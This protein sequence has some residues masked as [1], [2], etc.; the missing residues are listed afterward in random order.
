MAR[1]SNDK[2]ESE[3]GL[4]MSG[5]YN[6]GDHIFFR[7]KLTLASECLNRE[8]EVFLKKFEDLI[9]GVFCRIL[10]SQL[11]FKQD[12]YQEKYIPIRKEMDK[13][14][15]YI[16]LEPVFNAWYDSEENT[17]NFPLYLLNVFK[18]LYDFQDLEKTIRNIDF[19]DLDT[20]QE[21]INNECN[22]KQRLLQFKTLLSQLPKYEFKMINGEWHLLWFDALDYKFKCDDTSAMIA[23]SLINGH[24]MV[25]WHMR[26]F[27]VSVREQY[28]KE[29]IDMLLFYI[30]EYSSVDIQE[31][32]FGKPDIV[33]AWAEEICADYF[34][35]TMS[36]QLNDGIQKQRDVYLAIAYYYAALRVD[37]LVQNDRLN[38]NQGLKL[39]ESHPPAAVRELTIMHW[40]AKD[41]EMPFIEYILTVAGAW[42]YVSSFFDETIM[43]LIKGGID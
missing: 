32:L 16:V 23:I 2:F 43:D 5:E 19:I 33:E 30:R 18:R 26:K 3:R 37:E 4:R 12:Y 21:P 6:I 31:F 22:R 24:E 14:N 27:K 29:A 7:G 9:K 34:A 8:Q 39:N 36:L 28:I 40:L 1:D 17:I 42:F 35:I 25:H 13:I 10:A 38:N 15:V 20:F 11:M 41:M